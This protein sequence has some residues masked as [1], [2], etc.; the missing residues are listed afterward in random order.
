MLGIFGS[1]FENLYFV[2]CTGTRH[3]AQTSFFFVWLNDSAAIQRTLGV[4]HRCPGIAYKNDTIKTKQRVEESKW[5][6]W[7][8]REQKSQS[9]QEAKQQVPYTPD[10]SSIV[11]VSG[12]WAS[13]DALKPFS[14]SGSF[15]K[16]DDWSDDTRVKTSNVRVPCG[17]AVEWRFALTVHVSESVSVLNYI[18]QL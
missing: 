17:H 3:K 14:H 10:N 8:G 6:V 2:F 5:Q 12:I 9:S 13:G 7:K 16:K 1:S 15:W 4:Y 11:Q 18:I